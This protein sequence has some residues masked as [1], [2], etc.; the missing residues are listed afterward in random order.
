MFATAQSLGATGW[1]M[2]GA[3][4]GAATAGAGGVAAATAA[5]TLHGKKEEAQDKEE[6]KNKYPKPPVDI[7][8]G[9]RAILAM[10]NHCGKHF[11]TTTKA[12]NGTTTISSK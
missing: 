7:K 9:E 2:T 12:R 8:P 5:A 10:C 1:F 11:W 6:A 4:A 3:Y